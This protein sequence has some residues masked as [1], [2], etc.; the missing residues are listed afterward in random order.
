MLPSV[1]RTAVAAQRPSRRA[2]TRRRSSGSDS[3]EDYEPG[4]SDFE[5]EVEEDEQDGATRGGLYADG[6][7]DDDG[8]DLSYGAS[9]SLVLHPAGAGCGARHGSRLENKRARNREAAR[10]MRQRQRQQISRLEVGGRPEGAPA[11][12]GS[13]EQRLLI[14]C[15]AGCGW[16]EVAACSA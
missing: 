7:D 14:N 16:G 8:S 9:P 12:C 5:M 6:D 13:W 1:C 2:A 3:D 11:A 15:P 4:D 10:R